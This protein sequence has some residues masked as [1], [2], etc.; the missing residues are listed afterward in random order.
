L[1]RNVQEIE[2]EAFILNSRCA[3]VDGLCTFQHGLADFIPEKERKRDYENACMV[4]YNISAD[5]K[6]CAEEEAEKLLQEKISWERQHFW[7]AMHI[8]ER[9]CGVCALYEFE[10]LGLAGVKIVGR[11]NTLEKKIKDTAFIRRLLSFLEEKK[12]AQKAFRQYA[13]K[14]YREQYDRPCI[15]FKCYYPSVLTEA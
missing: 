1:A 8:D 10:Q 6:G 15:V 13:Q 14:L 7:S 11:Q 12:P 4:L 3:N 5:V 2:L 9:P